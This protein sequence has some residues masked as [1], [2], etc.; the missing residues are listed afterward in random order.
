MVEINCPVCKDKHTY[1]LVEQQQEGF[2][3]QSQS[4]SKQTKESTAPPGQAATPEGSHAGAQPMTLIL[5]CP[6]KNTP[7]RYE[8]VFQTKETKPTTNTPEA[9]TQDEVALVEFSKNLFENS[10]TAMTDYAKVMITLVSGIFAT[11][12][13]I[14][15]FLGLSTVTAATVQAL[16][17]VWTAPVCFIVSVAIFVVGVALPIPVRS[18][19]GVKEKMESARSFLFW[20]KY[21]GSLAGTGFFI[22]G[23]YLILRIGAALLS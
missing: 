17:S 7:F 2:S 3:A 11:Y 13:A 21:I 10:I 1:E 6:E 5:T 16:P 12:F 15:K 19:L 4:V 14:L 23:L 22:C 9:L 8:G 18:S 20:F